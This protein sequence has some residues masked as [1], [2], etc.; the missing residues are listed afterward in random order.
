M[1]AHHTLTK[2]TPNTNTDPTPGTISDS[3]AEEQWSLELWH[4]CKE[5]E[6]TL[7]DGVLD[8]DK[9]TPETLLGTRAGRSPPPHLPKYTSTLLPY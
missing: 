1:V 9:E 6:K 4:S 2:K 5:L 7:R 8:F 3:F